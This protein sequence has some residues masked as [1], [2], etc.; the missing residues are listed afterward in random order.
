ML[1]KKAVQLGL[2]LGGAIV[3]ISLIV[4]FM[5]VEIMTNWWVAIT[6]GVLSLAL[7]VFF[8]LRLKKTPGVEVITYWQAFF[9][10]LIISLVSGALYFGYERTINFLDP[11]LIENIQNATIQKTVAFMERFDTPQEKID[12]TIDDMMQKFEEAKNATVAGMLKQF[13]MSLAWYAVIAFIL[14]IFVRKSPPVF[15]K[16]EESA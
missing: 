12:Q 9:A 10:I 11:H 3:L 1:N 13:C 4:Y 2:M 16:T 15:P 14:A 6:L 5:G 7:Q 8:S